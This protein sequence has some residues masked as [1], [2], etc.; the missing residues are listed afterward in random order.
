MAIED[1]VDGMEVYASSF[2]EMFSLPF[3][4][5]QRTCKIS[6][7]VSRKARIEIRREYSECR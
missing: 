1:G 5:T 6:V 4:I 2:G 3:P 7:V